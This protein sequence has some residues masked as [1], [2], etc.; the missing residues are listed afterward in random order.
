MSPTPVSGE[1]VT[2]TLLIAVGCAVVT[3]L[4][5]FA[6]RPRPTAL[7]LI[8]IYIATSLALVMTAA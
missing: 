6:R 8:A 4:V 3:V 5:S 1:A 2:G 7:G